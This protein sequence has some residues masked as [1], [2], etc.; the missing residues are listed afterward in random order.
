MP[1]PPFPA[2]IFD[3]DGTLADSF[4]PHVAFCRAMNES[5]GLGLQLPSLDDLPGCRSLAAAPMS[6]FMLK[7]G[8]PDSALP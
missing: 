7:A 3:N 6:E 8:F 1:V 5:L 4:P 2:V